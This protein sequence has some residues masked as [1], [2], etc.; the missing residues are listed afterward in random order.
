MYGQQL[1]NELVT[2]VGL[3]PTTVPQAIDT[4][5]DIVSVLSPSLIS[6]APSVGLEP[7]ETSVVYNSTSPS[8]LF[9]SATINRPRW[10]TQDPDEI[11]GSVENV[12]P[13]ALL[14]EPEETS[15]L[16]P[17]PDAAT[18]AEIH[19][20]ATT[21]TLSSSVPVVNATVAFLPSTSTASVSLELPSVLSTTSS[22]LTLML[23]TRHC[24]ALQKFE[25]ESATIHLYRHRSIGKWRPLQLTCY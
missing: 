24:K 6:N 22:S 18:V 9:A 14:L 19:E 7:E 12:L 8:R 5:E 21:V 15:I 10:L 3:K 23:S 11:G 17:T 1:L 4:E 2:I 13:W 16:A 20:N 25:L